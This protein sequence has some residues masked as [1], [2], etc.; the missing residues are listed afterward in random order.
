[1]KKLIRFALNNIPRKHLI[2]FSYLFRKISQYTHRG[3]NVEC[4]ICG[5]TYSK[6]L[7]YGYHAV[8]NSVLCPKCLSLERHRMV[9]LYLKNRTS[10]FTDPLKV[11][12]VAPEQCFEERFKKLDNLD[13]ITADIESPLADYKCDV[14]HLPFHNDIFDVV[15]CNH[16]LEHVDDDAKAMSEILRVMKPGAFAIL[17]VPLSFKLE[18]TF[19]DPSITSAKDRTKYYKQYDHKRLY[20]LDY[21][22]MLRMAGFEIP[23]SNYLEELSIEERT[24]YCL[25]PK[26]FM[27][28]YKKPL[29]K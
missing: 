13:Y 22:E 23:E 21:P 9:W 28:G 18:K 26:E 8:R 25:P 7:S 5:S 11:L 15:I 3:N 20:G 16:V 2:R 17:L 4:P 14:Q 10:F 12:H 1:M 27:Y 29:T 6:F 19:E 24:R